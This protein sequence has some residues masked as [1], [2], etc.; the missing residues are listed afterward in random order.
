MTMSKMKWKR[1]LA[2]VLVACAFGA[3][4]LRFAWA[5]PGQGATTTPIAGPTILDEIDTK[6]E[7]GD[8]E[9]EFKTK[10]LSDVYVSHIRVVPG[11]FSGWH[12]H[13]GPSIVSVKS[14]TATFYQADDPATPHDVPAGTG[15]VEDAGRVHI[16]VNEGDTDLEIVVVQIVPLGAPRRIDAPAP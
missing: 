8:H 12:F 1:M 10:G 13:P 6:S 14:G 15:F 9:V 2:G 16:L 4:A 11:G 5:T 3:V 7:T